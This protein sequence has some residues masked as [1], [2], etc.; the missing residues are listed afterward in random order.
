MREMTRRRENR[1]VKRGRIQ[2]SGHMNRNGL[3]W[4][5]VQVRFGLNLVQN[6]F[7]KTL[8]PL[9]REPDRWSGSPK[10]MNLGPNHGQVQLGSGS[11]QGSEPNLTIPTSDGRKA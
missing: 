5:L 2:P 1:E 7:G 8:G 6:P 3:Q 9:N 4:A 10:G 11:N